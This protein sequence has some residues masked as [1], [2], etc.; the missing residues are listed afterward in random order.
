MKQTSVYDFYVL[1]QA[2]APLSNWTP[3]TLDAH[4]AWEAH[5]AHEQLSFAA[6]ED[7]VLLPA[8]RDAAK[9]LIVS[10]ETAFGKDIEAPPLP[11]S[12]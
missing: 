3:K 2:L 6:L 8:S 10:L 9:K 4:I 11:I 1:G 12:L 7:S 5:N